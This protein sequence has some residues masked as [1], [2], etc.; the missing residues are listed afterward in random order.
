MNW[1][2]THPSASDIQ[3]SHSAGK[4]GKIVK[5]NSRQGKH[6]EVKD[7]EKT[8]IKPRE[9]ENVQKKFNLKKTIAKKKLL[10]DFDEVI[11]EE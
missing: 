3:G 9:F 6:R 11:F 5:S 7:F 10:S 8:Q 2:I 1:F 4:T